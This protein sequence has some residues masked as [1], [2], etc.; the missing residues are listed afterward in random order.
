MRPFD[1]FSA[2]EKE[3]MAG[4]WKQSAANQHA[5]AFVDRVERM[6]KIESI[7]FSPGEHRSD[8]EYISDCEDIADHAKRLA[9]TL[10]NMPE[11]AL[12]ASNAAEWVRAHDPVPG[13]TTA[14]RNDLLEMCGQHRVGDVGQMFM[15]LLTGFYIAAEASAQAMSFRKQRGPQKPLERYLLGKIVSL[16]RDE[17]GMLP[18]LSQNGSFMGFLRDLSAV[19]GMEFGR[20]LLKK[21]LDEYSGHVGEDVTVRVP[22]DA[23]RDDGLEAHISSGRYLAYRR[24]TDTG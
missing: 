11:F 16:Y 15:H 3:Q 14:S 19:I 9:I 8:S 20:D 13:M 17:F 22:F 23:P 1:G 18:K 2:L 5:K 7:V 10:R 4:N 24:K 6:L 21:E 12:V